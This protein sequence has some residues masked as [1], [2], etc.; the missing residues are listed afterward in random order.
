M[1]L[2]TDKTKYYIIA[3]FSA[4]YASYCKE[5]VFGVFLIIAMTNCLF[6][7]NT[8]SKKEK[9]FY[10]SLVINGVIFLVTYYFLSFKDASVLYNQGRVDVAGGK[11]I[12]SDIC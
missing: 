6:K 5:P 8:A 2:E 10:A 12:G 3:I 1:A 4:A 9:N 11:F 7:F